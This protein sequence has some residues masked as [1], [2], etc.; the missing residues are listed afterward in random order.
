M[1]GGNLGK[2]NISQA[3]DM[4]CGNCGGDTFAIGYKFKKMSK[5]LTGAASDEIIPF[6]IY[7]CVECGEPLEE[8]LQPELRKP[9]ENGEGKNPLGLI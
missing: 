6:E 1:I 3:K 2:P 4:A 7:L 8:L 5:L 9:K